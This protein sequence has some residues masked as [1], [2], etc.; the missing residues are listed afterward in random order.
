MNEAWEKTQKI[1]E[2]K[3]KLQKELNIQINEDKLK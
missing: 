3:E 1:K 2:L